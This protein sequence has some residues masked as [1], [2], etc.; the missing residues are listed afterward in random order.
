MQSFLH[1][2]CDNCYLGTKLTI[3]SIKQSFF[4][5]CKACKIKTVGYNYYI[6]YLCIRIGSRLLC[7]AL[8]QNQFLH[9]SKTLVSNGLGVHC[10]LKVDLQMM[11]CL[12]PHRSARWRLFYPYK[13]TPEQKS[14]LG[15]N[16]SH[17]YPTIQGKWNAM[18][19]H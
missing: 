12:R 2:C 13:K 15:E 9:L 7:R 14:L 11:S 8:R 5:I 17:Q 16:N 3:I 1:I 6:M 19:S 10:F 4:G 18:A